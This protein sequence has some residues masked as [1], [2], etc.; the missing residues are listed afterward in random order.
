MIPMMVESGHRAIITLFDVWG[1]AN[2]TKAS[3]KNARELIQA[4]E[5]TNGVAK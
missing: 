4:T 2:L 1:I 5:K 3:I